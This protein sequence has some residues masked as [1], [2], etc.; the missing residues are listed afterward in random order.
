[1][2]RLL[3]VVGLELTSIDLDDHYWLDSV[4][5]LWH[6]I[7]NAISFEAY[8]FSSAKSAERSNYQMFFYQRQE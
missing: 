2:V 7:S 6:L 1:M 5:V 4:G 8:L 3:I